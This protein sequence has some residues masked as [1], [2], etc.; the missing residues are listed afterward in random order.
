MIEMNEMKPKAL[1]NLPSYWIYVVLGSAILSFISE[2]VD[3]DGLWYYILGLCATLAE[4]AVWTAIILDL[5]K[6]DMISPKLILMLGL[7][8]ISSLG[9]V[10]I[11]SDI[12]STGAILLIAIGI[13]TCLA[14]V[15]MIISSYSG[16]F[17]KYVIISTLCSFGIG[18]LNVINDDH[19]I[20]KGYVGCLLFIYYYEY[21]ALLKAINE[22]DEPFIE[23]DEPLIS[24]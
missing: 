11:G 5:K 8:L 3:P 14:S 12:E 13:I 15:F 20:F 21:S 16:L 24:E 7:F 1:I 10:F 17:P 22:G 19:H 6:R 23:E 18:V 4:I 9:L 2:L